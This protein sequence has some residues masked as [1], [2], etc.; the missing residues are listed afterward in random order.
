MAK[1]SWVV[2]WTTGSNTPEDWPTFLCL[3]AIVLSTFLFKPVCI[4]LLKTETPLPELW[5]G[6][7]TEFLAI[8]V[9]NNDFS[10]SYFLCFTV[11][12]VFTEFNKKFK[13]LKILSDP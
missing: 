12:E 13:F 9:R 2:Q 7:A 5:D 10:P 6:N 4:R 1:Q 11:G 3:S 8:I